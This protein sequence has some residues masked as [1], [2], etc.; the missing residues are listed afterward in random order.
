MLSDGDD[1]DLA[2]L[3][4][5]LADGMGRS[6]VPQWAVPHAVLKTLAMLAGRSGTFAKLSGELHVDSRAFSQGT[7]WRPPVT[8]SQGLLETAA[9][10]LKSF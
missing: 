6:H 3:V 8:L 2:S 5:L 1:I 4:R 9:A 7:G 10:H